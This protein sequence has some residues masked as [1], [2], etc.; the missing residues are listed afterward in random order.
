[1]TSHPAINPTWGRRY[2]AHGYGFPSVL[3]TVTCPTGTSSRCFGI[4]TSFLAT[5]APIEPRTVPPDGILEGTSTPWQGS[6]IEAKY[7]WRLVPE[8]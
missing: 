5:S 6:N 3:G 4:R 1:M 7:N 8:R 2:F